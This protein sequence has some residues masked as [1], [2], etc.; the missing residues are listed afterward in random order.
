M[1]G[2]WIY[3]DAVENRNGAYEIKDAKWVSNNCALLTVGQTTTVKD[4]SEG[5][6]KYEYILKRGGNFTIPLSKSWKA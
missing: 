5:N 6:T 1:I 2:A 3:A 4:F